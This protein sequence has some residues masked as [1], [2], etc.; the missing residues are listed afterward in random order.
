VDKD[1]PVNISIGTA[2][3]PDTNT[4]HLGVGAG[5]TSFGSG[6]V[7]IK[8]YSDVDGTSYNFNGLVGTQVTTDAGN[9]GSICPIGYLY[10]ED[11]DD[12]L[13]GFGKARAFGSFGGVAFGVVA[14]E[15]ATVQVVPS[16]A[17]VF[18][19]TRQTISTPDTDL[20]LGD[21]SGIV[22]VALGIQLKGIYTIT[23]EWRGDFGSALGN[24][25]EFR[26][27]FTFTH[28]RK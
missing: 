1:H 26:L 25:H 27:T 12:L 3:S 2:F 24:S 14:G 15:S 18:G 7:D 6:A 9:H 4:L 22:R 13:G 16:V 23:P 21:A 28:Q 5:R 11:A 20:S 19:G 17:L 8:N 10:Y